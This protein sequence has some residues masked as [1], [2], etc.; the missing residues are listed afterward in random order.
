MPGTAEL[1][2]CSV[3]LATL[4]NQS[5]HLPIKVGTDTGKDVETKVLLDSGTGGVL[6]SHEFAEKNSLETFPLKRSIAVRNI[7]GTPNKKGMI[8]N[9]TK[10]SLE[11]N[12]KKFGTSFLIARLGDESVIL[13]LPW[14]QKINL[15]ID[16]RK[17]TFEFREDLRMNQI[18]RIVAKAREKWGM[19]REKRTP[20]VTVEEI[21]DEEST[22]ETWE[23]A[24]PIG[25][26]E[27]ENHS[28]Q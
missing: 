1:S 6:I 16:W 28:P 22:P 18:G 2:V 12:R 26:Q 5:M 20:K 11:I 24:E 8:S 25:P 4:E 27:Q 14:L 7:D 19:F 3:L 21:L 23:D 15:A 13:G 9:Y 10:A 17:G